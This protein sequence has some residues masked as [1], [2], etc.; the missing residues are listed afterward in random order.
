MENSGIA[1]V[2]TEIAELLEIKGDDPFRIRSYKNAAMVVEGLTQSLT[3]LYEQGGLNG[4]PGIG[5]GLRQK[6]VEMLETGACA[7]HDELLKELPAGLL[8][9]LNVRGVGPKKA[10]LFYKELGISTI[11]ALEKA[12]AAHALAGLSHIGKKT[13]E[14]I[15]KGIMELKT[16]TGRVTLHSAMQTAEA[17]IKYLKKTT[18]AGDVQPAGSIRRWTE[19]IGDIDILAI[20]SEHER[21]IDAFVRYPEAKET[22]SKGDTKAAIALKNGLRVDIRVLDADS[23]GSAMQYFTGSKSHNVI[24]REMAKKKG[25]KINEYGVFDEKTG[26]RLAGLTEADVYKQI[27]LPLILPEYREGRGEIEAALAG[28]LPKPLELCD[29]RGDLHC[30]TDE[31]D[32]AHSLRDMAQEAMRLGYEYMAITDHSRA[33]GVAHGLD[34]KRALKQMDEIDAFNASLKKAGKRFVVL[35][36]AEVDI[37][38]DGTLDHEE[39]VLG[40]LDCVVGAIHSGWNM[41]MAEM[42]GRIIKGLNTGRIDILAHPTGRLIGIRSAYQVDMNA[43]METAIMTGVAL[44]LNSS[45]ERLD[46]NDVHCRAAMEKGI[47]V[48]ISTDAHS[49]SQLSNMTYGIHTARRGWLEK[50]NVLNARPLKELLTWLKKRRS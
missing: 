10:A 36:S 1:K 45:P 2:F 43:I 9:I 12:A 3:S 40:R 38:A 4:I 14:N 27:G 47:P 34:A 5:L 20:S 37:R 30:H 48:A 25:L 8:D 44:E 41:T 13:E 31:S 26:E 15:L 18:N 49:A 32:G 7:F 24:I 33:I 50:K 17:I 6:I 46:L 28:N 21:I 29:I 16:M 19:S 39:A 23:Y 11:E 35:K 42:T 22:V